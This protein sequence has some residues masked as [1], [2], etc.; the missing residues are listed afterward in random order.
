MEKFQKNNKKIKDLRKQ[1]A[2]AHQLIKK[3]QQIGHEEQGDSFNQTM[4][5]LINSYKDDDQIKMMYHQ[6]ACSKEVLRKDKHILEKKFKRQQLI[7][8]ENEQN[9]K[10]SMQQVLQLKHKFKKLTEFV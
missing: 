8:K 3:L 1:V 2:E 9:L 10:L 6:L 7:N 4:N 5:K